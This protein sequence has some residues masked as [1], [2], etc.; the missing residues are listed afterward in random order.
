[1]ESRKQH[2]EHVNSA[3]GLSEHVTIF[4]VQL[5]A[6]PNRWADLTCYLPARTQ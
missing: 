6:N 4:C 3:S 2:H 5:F 1:M